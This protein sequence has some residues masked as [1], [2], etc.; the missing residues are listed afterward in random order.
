MH[1]L[2]C[3]CNGRVA[4][5][6][7]APRNH[8]VH[9]HAKR[10]QVAARVGLA[11]LRLFGREIC[12]GAH[13]RAR[14]GKS[15][16]NGRTHGAGNAEVGN[17]HLA[18]EPNQNVARLNVAVHHTVVVSNSKRGGHLNSNVARLIDRQFALVAQQAGK[19]SALHK[20]HCNEIGVVYFAPV[21]HGNNVG[22][23]QVGCRLRLASKPLDE[24]GIICKLRKQHLQSNRA[25]EQNVARQKHFGHAPAAYASLHPVALINEGHLF[26]SHFRP[27][28][29]LIPQCN[30]VHP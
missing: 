21:V 25:I 13:D 10:I 23:R 5:E 4:N 12:C 27:Q 3:N 19:R 17:L 30:S 29:P 2:I 28:L 15:V 18:I 1:L 14:L 24:R 11:A 22:V 8:F 20:L 6:W 16:F 7:R 26:V 9:H